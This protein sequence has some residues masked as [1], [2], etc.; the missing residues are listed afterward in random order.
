MSLSLLSSFLYET[1]NGDGYV[2][3]DVWQGFATQALTNVFMYM[4]IAL[5]VILLGVGLFVKFYKQERLAGYLKVAG[6]ICA[7]FIVTVIVTMLGLSYMQI[8][9][10]GYEQ[11]DML[12]YYVMVPAIMLAAIAVAGIIAAYIA[13]MFSQKTFKITIITVASLFGA[14]LLIDFILL[15][16]YFNS[17]TAENNNWEFLTKQENI[18]LYVSAAILIVVIAAAAVLC[19][20]KKKNSFDSKSISYAA[21]CIAMSFALSYIKFFEMPQ[22]GSLTLASLVP[23][24]LYSYMFG[25]KKGVLAGLIYGVL[26]AVQ[27]PWIIHPAQFLLDYPIAFAAI[28]LGGI[29]GEL[30]A[31]EKLPQV[32]FAL[33]AIVAGLLRYISHLLSGVFAFNSYAADHG[34]NAWIYSLGY[35]SFVWPDI[36]IAI[37]VGV[38]LLSSR[39]FA[40]QVGKVQAESDKTAAP[41]VAETVEENA[42]AENEENN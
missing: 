24:L 1:E 8:F 29:F 34:L 2:Y 3:E 22:G 21:I 41:A 26:Q 32:K 30:K 23:L 16:V 14:M 13:S 19:G 31:L 35:N 20:R 18:W 6:G 28:G 39:A 17:G 27:D 11:Y 25:T 7:G 33:G 36:A 12:L 5:A 10:K 4:A 40:A 37:A 38:I 9:E 15:A 42:P